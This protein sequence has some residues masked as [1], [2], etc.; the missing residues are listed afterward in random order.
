MTDKSIEIAIP[1]RSATADINASLVKTLQSL[2]RPD[3]LSEYEVNVN[4]HHLQPVDAN[5]NEM[6]KSFLEKPDAEILIMIDSDIVPPV[7]ILKMVEHDEPVVSAVCTIKKGKV[8]SPTVMKEEGDSYRQVEI[9]EVLEERDED[10]GLLEVDGVGTGCLLIRRDVLE[11]M[12]PPAFKFIQ[13]E[14][15]GLKL[16]EDFYFSRKCKENDINMYVDTTQICSHF[17]TVDLTEY[18]NVVAE[19]RQD[20]IDAQVE[21]A[22]S[23]D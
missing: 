7:D 11:N 3:S 4:F 14:Y 6:V 2:E 15:G 22:E 12:Q 1:S 13:N 20:S 8:P 17:K 9:S 23:E 18:A 5:R 16:G 19:A 10:S 21:D